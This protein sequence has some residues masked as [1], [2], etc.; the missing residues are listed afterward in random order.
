MNIY[1]FHR[2]QI[3]IDWKKNGIN[4]RMHTVAI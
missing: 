3:H 2:L 4:I 1:K